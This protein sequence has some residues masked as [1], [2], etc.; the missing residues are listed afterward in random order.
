MDATIVAIVVLALCLLLSGAALA[1]WYLVPATPPPTTLPA[2][3]APAVAAPAAAGAGTVIAQNARITYYWPSSNT[4]P[5]S[6]ACAYVASCTAKGS[7]VPS[8]AAHA[9]DGS[10]PYVKGQTYTISGPGMTP[11]C[12]RIDDQCAACKGTWMDVFMPEG[13]TLPFDYATTVTAGC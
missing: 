12:V 1:I 6:D 4:P 11:F 10:S 2:V 7:A 9:L 8:S 3:A 5:G 13:Q